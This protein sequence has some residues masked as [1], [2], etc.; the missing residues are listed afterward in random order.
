MTSEYF[1]PELENIRLQL[2]EAKALV[3]RLEEKKSE[4]LKEVMEQFQPMGVDLTEEEAEEFM[5]AVEGVEPG[6][7]EH[8]QKV[9]SVFAQRF[10]QVIVAAGETG[11]I[12][13]VPSTD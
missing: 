3:A 11:L 4:K 9:S 1:D 10:P 12:F 7:P 13:R 8:V 6:S 5:S 2:E